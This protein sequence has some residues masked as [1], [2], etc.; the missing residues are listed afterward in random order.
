LSKTDL[1]SVGRVGRPHGV[2]GSFFVEDASEAEERFAVGAVL[3]VEGEPVRVVGSKR[4]SGGR[5]VI[6]LDRPVSRGA[7]LAVR[8]DELPPPEEDA[9][10]VFQLVGLQV[11]EEGGRALGVV[12]DVEN[13]PGNDAL[14]LD[15]GLLLP[16]VDACVLDVDL[17]ARR[18]L[19]ARGFAD[20]E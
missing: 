2:D 1:V 9:Y 7:A 18:I 17:D 11:E 13:M 3:L 19:V 14:V 16:M 12:A 10:Y 4:G 6:K 5:R 20:A 15:G 8:R